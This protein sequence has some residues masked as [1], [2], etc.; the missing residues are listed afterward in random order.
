VQGFANV[1]LKYFL[2]AIFVN[3]GACRCIWALVEVIRHTVAVAIE[4]AAYRIN[5]YASRCIRALIDI[6]GNAITIRI[7]NFWLFRRG[8]FGTKGKV[9]SS[10]NFTIYTVVIVGPHGTSTYIKYPLVKKTTL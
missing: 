2:A 3:Q 6:I 7:N 1:A 5:C 8:R 4:W 10:V 9:D